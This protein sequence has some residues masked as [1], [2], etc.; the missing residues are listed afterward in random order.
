MKWWYLAALALLLQACGGGDGAASDSGS[1]QAVCSVADQRALL[2]RFMGQEYYWYAQMGTPDD[3]AESLDAYFQSLLY[4]PVDRFSFSEPT[5]AHNQLFVEGR[6]VGFGYSLVWTDD[7]RATMRVR[8]VEPLSPVARAGLAR[9]DTVLSIDGY[10]PAQVAAGVLPLVNTPGVI[11]SFYVRKVSGELRSITVRSEDFALSPVAG[12]A[13]FDVMRN[14]A[15]VKVAYLAYHQ[16]VGYTQLE[17]AQAFALFREQGASE[18]ILD[19]RYNGGGSVNVSRDLAGLI[20]G[21]R[22]AGQTYTWLQYNDRLPANKFPITFSQQA[23]SGFDRVVV[24]GSGATAS[25]SELLIN[26]LRPFM[27]VVL[28]GE[29]T[30]GKPFG[31]SPRNFCGITYN[32]V[33]FETTNALGVGGYTAGFT[34]DCQVADDLDHELADPA[35]RRLRAALDYVATGRCDSQPQA[36]AARRPRAPAEVFGETAPSQMFMQ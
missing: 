32:A 4:K 17:L 8:N 16:F 20:G 22:T 25:A 28:L 34:P 18:I 14:G 27:D 33:E 2:D 23:A 1:P 24:I 36:F 10:S 19:L 31:F 13:T 7:T 35:E 5:A 26:G 30:Y 29:T 6:R 12:T 9:G 21:V 11:R 3:K 15:P